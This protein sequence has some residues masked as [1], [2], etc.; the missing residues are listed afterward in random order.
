VSAIEDAMARI[1]YGKHFPVQQLAARITA[2]REMVLREYRTLA[3]AVGCTRE[4][5]RVGSGERCPIQ[6]CAS[7]KNRKLR[8]IPA[9]TLGVSE[10]TLFDKRADK[11]AIGFSR[12]QL[13]HL[14]AKR[15]PRYSLTRYAR[16]AE[17]LRRYRKSWNRATLTRARAV[18]CSSLTKQHSQSPT[19]ILEILP[20]PSIFRNRQGAIQIAVTLAGYFGH[21]WVPM[22]LRQSSVSTG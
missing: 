4:N 20:I 6:G 14:G 3:R 21:S 11:R 12:M 13:R 16:N 9:E 17:S 19:H 2:L 8:Q 1:A 22:I 7:V 10:A 18:N 5:E 15:N